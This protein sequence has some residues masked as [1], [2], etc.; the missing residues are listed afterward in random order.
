MMSPE[1][2]VVVS[3]L[4]CLAGAVL[5][6]LVS[7]SKTIAGW[8]AFFITA[9]TAVLIFSAVAK[10]LITGPS[11]HPAAFWAGTVIY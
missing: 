9:S 6:L 5:T 8:L 7:R 2:A 1:Q 4:I 11:P 10:V 3:I